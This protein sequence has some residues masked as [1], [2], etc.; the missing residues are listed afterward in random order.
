MVTPAGAARRRAA[1]D[2]VGTSMGGLIGMGL[3]SLPLR[4]PIAV[5]RLVLNDVGPTIEPA[6]IA[7]HRH[8]P[9]ARRLRFD[10]LERGRRLPAGHLDRASGRTRREQWLALTRP[11]LQAATATASRCTTTRRSRVPFRAHHAG[12]RGRRRRR[13]SGTPT[14]RSR[15]PTLLLRGAE[16]DLLSRDT[17][18][19]MTRARPEGAAASNSPASAM[20]RRSSHADQVAVVR[21]FLLVAMKTLARSEPRRRRRRSSSCSTTDRRDAEQSMPQPADAL[22]ARARLRRAAASPASTLDTGENALAHADASRRSCRR[23]AARAVDARR[24]LPGLRGRPSEQARGGRSPR[25]SA[26]RYA[27]PASRTR[28]SWC[29][30]SAQ[31]ARR[32]ASA[33]GERA[34]QTER[35]RKMLLAFSRDLRVVLLRLASRLQTLRCFAASKQPC[36]RSRWRASRCRCSR[37]SPTGSA[38]GRSSGSWRTSRSASSSPSTTSRSRGCSTRSGSSASSASSALRARLDAE[39]RGARHARRRCRAGPSTST[40]SGRRCAARRSTS[41]SVLDVRALRVIV[42]RR[43][44]LLC[45]AGARA[46]ALRADRRGVRRLHRAAEAERLPVAAHRGAGRATGRA[47]EI[48][49]RTAGDARARR[50][51]RRRALGLQGSGREGLRAASARRQLRG[52]GRRGAHGRAAPAARLGARLRRPRRRSPTCATDRRCFDDRIYVFT[53]Q[54]A[55]VELPAGRDADRLRL[56][57]CTPTSAIAAAAPRSTARWCR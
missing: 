7:A 51:R 50:A 22:G 27:E 26:S 4:S 42:P 55:I 14:T 45:G 31:R 44:R 24:G 30:C 12:A 6:A 47:V 17:A 52:A 20:R 5:R 21:E 25:P 1:C 18:Q 29:R 34:Q 15:C 23:S 41:T 54:A 37:R 39:L 48:Q 19:A 33:D 57:A 13:R 3:A 16:S 2:W 49:I 56:R 28:A 40:A 9:R 46:R 43:A 10:T 53:P 32:A 38:S 8:L 11:M 36:P 35:V